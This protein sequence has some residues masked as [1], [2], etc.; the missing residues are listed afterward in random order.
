MKRR[1]ATA[2]K[3]R[4]DN[5]RVLLR[6]LP[7]AGCVAPHKLKYRSQKAAEAAA[8][9]QWHRDHRILWAYPCSDHFHLTSRG[10]V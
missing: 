7:R 1:N 10:L 6:D 5:I 9:K 3:P 4:E 2:P 8:D